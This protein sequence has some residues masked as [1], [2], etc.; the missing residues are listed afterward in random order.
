VR[1]FALSAGDGRLNELRLLSASEISQAVTARE[2]SAREVVEAHLEGAD[3]IAPLHALITSCPEQAL[4]R[5]TEGVTGPL[6]GVPL[7]VKDLFDTALI[8]T[9]YGS[10]IYRNHTPDR[11]AAAVALL[12]EAGAVVIGKANLHEFAW[13]TTSQNPHWGFVQN[14]VRPGHVAG[15]SSGGNA[16]ALAAFV[17]T[18]GLGTDTAG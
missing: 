10:T 6:A 18:I 14:P 9:T 12:E 1:S 17:S 8:R 5:T 16:A 3:E 4:A 15:G 11:T 13:G 2:L 7:L